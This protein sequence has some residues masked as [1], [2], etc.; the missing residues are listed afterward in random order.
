MIDFR[1]GMQYFIF[2]PNY[3]LMLL[4]NMLCWLNNE[5]TMEIQYIFKIDSLLSYNYLCGI[6]FVVKNSKGILKVVL[7]S[8]LVGSFS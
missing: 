8:S 3:Q 1:R 2:L 7:V 5:D 6:L 4:Y